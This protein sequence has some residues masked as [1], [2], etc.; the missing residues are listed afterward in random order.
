MLERI[1]YDRLY[2]YLNKN[3]LFF[4]KQFEFREG[5][6]TEHALTEVID[7]IYDSFNQNTYVLGSS[8]IQNQVTKSWFAK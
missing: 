5:H 2:N 4:E 3:N 8:E 7:N 1:M 6:P